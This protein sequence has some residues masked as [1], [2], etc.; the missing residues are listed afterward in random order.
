M[1][2][3]GWK[4]ATKSGLRDDRSRLLTECGPTLADSSFSGGR[5]LPWPVISLAEAP[6]STPSRLRFPFL[7]NLRLGIDKRRGRRTNFKHYPRHDAD[8]DTDLLGKDRTIQSFSSNPQKDGKEGSSGSI[9]TPN[10][11]L[12]EQGQRRKLASITVIVGKCLLSNLGVKY[13]ATGPDGN[14]VVT[15]NEPV[16]GC[17]PTNQVNKVEKRRI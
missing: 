9:S 15:T 12:N 17:A 7:N 14:V 16:V 6:S 1:V 5:G 11:T 3:L 10:S 8:I 13:R 2:H 4:A